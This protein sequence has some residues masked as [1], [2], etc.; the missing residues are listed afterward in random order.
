MQRPRRWLRRAWSLRA[1]L[2]AA[3]PD[4]KATVSCDGTWQRRGFASK[5]GVATVL[6]VNPA[7]PAKVVDVRVASNR[8]DACSKAKSRGSRR[9]LRATSQPAPRT[10]RAALA[11]W[12]RP[13]GTL[14]IFRRC[15]DRHQLRYRGYLGDGDSKSFA[16]VSKAA[17]PVY[18][19]TAVRSRNLN[20][21][22]MYRR[23]WA[24]TRSI[25][26]RS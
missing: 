20:V 21:V 26:L 12:S 16:T 19:A 17:P 14:T 4:D 15:E 23:E 11:R 7:G 8:C 1:E 10:T 5:N 22:D 2:R 6:S 9:G 25:R 13:D 3:L 24:N 18:S